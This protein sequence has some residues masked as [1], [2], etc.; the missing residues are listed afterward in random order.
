VT[1]ADNIC[2]CCEQQR[3]SLVG[4][5]ASGIAPYSCAW[6]IECLRHG[7]EPLW[8]VKHLLEEAGP[9]DY[10]LNQIVYHNGEFKPYRSIDNGQGQDQK[11]D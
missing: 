1:M 10:L 4:V 2:D 8:I 6:C 9:S 11:G 3:K 7:A 5:A